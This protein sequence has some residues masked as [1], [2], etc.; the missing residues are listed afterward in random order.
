M[1]SN[2]FDPEVAYKILKLLGRFSRLNGGEIKDLTGL[3]SEEINDGVDYLK[4]LGAVKIK[5]K[6]SPYDFLYISISKDGVKLYNK[7]F[8][9]D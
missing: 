8:F 9:E 3:T 4:N 5:G 7:K 2:S 6:D 1:V